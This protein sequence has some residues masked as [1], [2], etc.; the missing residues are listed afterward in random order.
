MIPNL[1]NASALLSAK[2]IDQPIADAKTKTTT[3]EL[4]FMASSLFPL[5]ERKFNI[6]SNIGNF[7]NNSVIISNQNIYLKELDFSKLIL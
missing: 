3:A 6:I 2:V 7:V 4:K 5:W 1:L